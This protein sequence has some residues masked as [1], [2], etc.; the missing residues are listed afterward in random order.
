MSLWG[1]DIDEHAPDADDI[2]IL[3]ERTY[4]LLENGCEECGFMHIIFQAAISV[5]EQS[6]VFILSVECPNCMAVYKTIM[7]VRMI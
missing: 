5:E 1:H 3:Q 2:K 4:E 6:K 7:D